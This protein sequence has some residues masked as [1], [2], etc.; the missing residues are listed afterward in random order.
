MIRVV[1]P[2][3]LRRVKLSEA[4][5]PKYYIHGAELPE[6]YNT[7]RYSWRLRGKIKCL[8]DNKEGHF[9]VKNAK[10]AYKPTYQTI[11]G[12]EIYARMHERKRMLIVHSLKDHFKEHISTQIKSIPEHLYPLSISMELHAPFGYADWDVDN[13]WI[14]HKCFL[15]SLRDLNL[16]PDDSVLHVR[17]AGQTTLVPTT[18]T[19]TMIFKIAE[20]PEECAP[21][22][23]NMITVEESS[24]GDPGDV[25]IEDNVAII[26]TG[27]TTVLFGAAKKAI[28]SVMTH[29]LNTFSTVLVPEQIYN[30]YK[31]FFDESNYEG[32][33]KV[34]SIKEWKN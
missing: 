24:Q 15:D 29:A 10:S 26:Y 3:Y 1:I 28:R 14:Y 25:C 23:A 11:A 2:N 27:K 16:I 21:A 7:D 17:Q 13:L 30:R 6:K 33:V 12:N 20:A 18:D 32:K 19:P 5:R 31:D 9:V 4:R 8:Y 22:I 34:T